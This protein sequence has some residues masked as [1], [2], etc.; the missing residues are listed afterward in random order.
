MS[1]RPVVEWRCKD[2]G[3]LMQEP[4]RVGCRF[5]PAKP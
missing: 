3:C 1:D 5:A 2:C 4:H